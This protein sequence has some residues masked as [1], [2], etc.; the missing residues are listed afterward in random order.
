VGY[1]LRI[2]GIGSR[3]SNTQV[4]LMWSTETINGIKPTLNYWMGMSLSRAENWEKTL[5]LYHV[6]NGT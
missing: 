3:Y 6:G 4:T 2:I 1:Y 5:C